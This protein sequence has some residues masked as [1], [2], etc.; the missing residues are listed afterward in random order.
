MIHR[1]PR[2]LERDV[3][4]VTPR[5][6]LHLNQTPAVEAIRNIVTKMGFQRARFDFLTAVMT[7]CP[8]P[9]A[10]SYAIS[11]DISQIAFNSMAVIADAYHP[12][13][14]LHATGAPGPK[15]RFDTYCPRIVFDPRFG[16]F[17]AASGRI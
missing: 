9:L 3:V 6:S 4:S 11:T 10:S 8:E 12:G 13:G 1:G 7:C 16:R 2:S 15:A 17:W 5:S 14:L